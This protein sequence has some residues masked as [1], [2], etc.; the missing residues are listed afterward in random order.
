MN[1]KRKSVRQ[2]GH[3]FEGSLLRKLQYFY[4]VYPVAAQKYCSSSKLRIYVKNWSNCTNDGLSIR[5]R[6]GRSSIHLR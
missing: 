4:I 2:K 5:L 3:H 1:F 6:I